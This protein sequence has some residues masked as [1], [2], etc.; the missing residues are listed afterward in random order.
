MEKT[1]GC[2]LHCPIG[3]TM[4]NQ[5]T[6][7]NNISLDGKKYFSILNKR[8]LWKVMQKDDMQGTIGYSTMVN[9]KQKGQSDGSDSDWTLRH[10]NLPCFPHF[11]LF[12]HPPV[13]FNCFLIFIF[14]IIHRS[15]S[16]V[17]LL[18]VFLIIQ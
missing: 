12:D 2:T 5:I 15:F 18:F 6:N 17:F 14:L 10:R 7:P 13:V 16:I 9:Q 8:F 1:S 4:G 3:C 11:Y